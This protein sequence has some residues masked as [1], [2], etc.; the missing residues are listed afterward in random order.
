MVRW[1]LYAQNYTFFSPIWMQQNNIIGNFFQNL[2]SAE[3]FLVK[4]NIVDL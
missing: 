1:K 4:K 2:E 3:T